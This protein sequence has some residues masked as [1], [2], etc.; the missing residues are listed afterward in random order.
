M[1]NFT[2]ANKNISMH[3]VDH[4]WYLKSEF[5]PLNFHSIHATDTVVFYHLNQVDCTRSTA[6][7]NGACLYLMCVT[8]LLI[9]TDCLMNVTWVHYF[10]SAFHFSCAHVRLL[11]E[12]DLFY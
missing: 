8:Q 3:R 1:S 9:S 10:F 12:I 11:V 6:R 5:G 4:F 2:T 7:Q